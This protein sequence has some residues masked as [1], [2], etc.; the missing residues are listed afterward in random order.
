MRTRVLFIL[1]ADAGVTKTDLEVWNQHLA[2][3][4]P[5]TKAGRIVILNKIDGLW[6]DLKSESEIDAEISR[7][8][9]NTRADAGRPG[10]AGVRRVGAEGAAREGQRRRCVA[11]AQPAARARGTRCRRSSFPPS[12]TSWAPRRRPSARARGRACARSS[13]RA[14]PASPS[15]SRN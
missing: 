5:A 7:Q 3:D 4:D 12:A 14:S 10:V 13:T 9:R 6:D 15:S 8:M 2:G 1:A 11:R